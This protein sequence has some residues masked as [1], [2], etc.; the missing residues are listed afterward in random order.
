MSWWD[1]Q[2]D[3]TNGEFILGFF[4]GVGLGTCILHL[5]KAIAIILDNEQAR[6]AA[7]KRREQ[8]GSGDFPGA[9]W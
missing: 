7:R 9:P 8:I 1:T 6:R 3:L 4:A 5:A 2:M